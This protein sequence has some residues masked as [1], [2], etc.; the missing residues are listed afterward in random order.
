MLLYANSIKFQYN[1]TYFKPLIFTCLNAWLLSISKHLFVEQV[2]L[3][4]ELVNVYE[5]PAAHRGGVQGAAAGVNPQPSSLRLGGHTPPSAKTN[6]EFHKRHKFRKCHPP[7][8]PQKKERR[9]AS[10]DE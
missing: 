1:K 8:P 10:V 5:K 4:V 6:L 7:P 3:Q 9:R 2:G